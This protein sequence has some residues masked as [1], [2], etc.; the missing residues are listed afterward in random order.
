MS[1]PGHH[2]K[3]TLAQSDNHLFGFDLIALVIAAGYGFWVPWIVSAE[4][5]MVNFAVNTG[6][7]VGESGNGCRIDCHGAPSHWLII[8]S[9]TSAA[10]NVRSRQ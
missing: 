8:L 1:W 5:V 2:V 9:I 6:P 10:N 3:S 4:S 7:S